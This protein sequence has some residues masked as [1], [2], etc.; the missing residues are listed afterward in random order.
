MNYNSNAC[1]ALQT[2]IELEPGES[3]EIAFVL[4]MKSDEE[5]EAVLSSYKDGNDYFIYV[6]MCFPILGCYMYSND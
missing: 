4:G 1:G 6:L 3:K 5:A 2:K